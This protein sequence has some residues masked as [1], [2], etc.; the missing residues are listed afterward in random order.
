MEQAFNIADRV[1]REDE[2]QA[3]LPELA[4]DVGRAD[5][6]VPYRAADD[7]PIALADFYDAEVEKAVRNAYGRDYQMFGFGDWGA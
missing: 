4:A 3:V 6:P 2:M 1:V 7:Q 5:A